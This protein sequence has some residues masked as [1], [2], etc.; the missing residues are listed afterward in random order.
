MLHGTCIFHLHLAEIYG[1]NVDKYTGPIEAYGNC[2]KAGQKTSYKW[3]YSQTI[4]PQLPDP[5]DPDMS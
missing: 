4:S 5:K 2:Y 3:S 1:V